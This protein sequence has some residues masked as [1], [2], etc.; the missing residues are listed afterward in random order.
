MEKL[1]TLIPQYVLNKQELDS[2]KKICDKENAEIKAIMRS[3]KLPSYSSNEYTVTY[4]VAKR[5]SINEEKA[6]SILKKSIGTAPDV[7]GILKVREYIDY[8]ALEDAIYRGKLDS[9]IVAE[10]NAAREV[11]EIE[12]LRISKRKDKEK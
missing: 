9:R 1:E 12:T 3:A 6:I 5:E 8:D 10:L 11:K 2:Y 7:Y 4:T